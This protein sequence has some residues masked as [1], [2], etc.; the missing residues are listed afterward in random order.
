MGATVLDVF[1]ETLQTTHIW[2]DELKTTVGPDKHVTSHVLEAVLRTLRD[3]LPPGLSIHRGAQLPLFVRGLSY[4]QWHPRQRPLKLRSSK[5]FLSEVAK[6]LESTR[7]V[8]AEQAHTS[9]FP[10]PQSLRRCRSDPPRAGGAFGTRWKLW[11]KMRKLSQ[12]RSTTGTNTRKLSQ[13]KECQ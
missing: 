9:S 4:D 6:G 11:R 1:D 5:Q 7:P 2:L 13:D 12:R 3:R 8:N 10:D